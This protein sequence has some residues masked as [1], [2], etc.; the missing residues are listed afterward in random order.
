MLLNPSFK[1]TTSFP[2]IARTTTGTSK[3]YTRKDFKSLGIGSLHEKNHFYVKIFL[4]KTLC[5]VLKVYFL[6][7]VKGCQYMAI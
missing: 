4:K 3:L 2:D 1:T 7:G 6:Y 5:K